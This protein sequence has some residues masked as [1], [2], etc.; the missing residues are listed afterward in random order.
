MSLSVLSIGVFSVFLHLQ[1]IGKERAGLRLDTEKRT[2]DVFLHRDP[3]SL[4]GMKCQGALLP[5]AT[6]PAGG[7]RKPGTFASAGQTAVESLEE[8]NR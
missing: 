1:H 3:S 7:G 8:K 6:P 2:S 5:P 4:H